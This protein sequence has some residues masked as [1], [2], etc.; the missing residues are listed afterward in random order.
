MRY[1][2]LFLL[3]FLFQNIYSQK[4]IEV[5]KYKIIQL[6]KIGGPLSGWGNID[7]DLMKITSLTNSDTLKYLRLSVDY[8][9]TGTKSGLITC[10]D[11]DNFLKAINLIKLDIA[12][13]QKI[14]YTYT[15]ENKSLIKILKD[16][17][18]TTVEFTPDPIYSNFCTFDFKDIDKLI[19]AFDQMDKFCKL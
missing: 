7:A 6:P 14:H 13:E 8:N 17:T 11:A 1:T 5:L 9:G 15:F 12:Q 4:G 3:G 18:R 10:R 2:I 19:Y 16:P